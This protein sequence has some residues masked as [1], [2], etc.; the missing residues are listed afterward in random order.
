[1]DVLWSPSADRIENSPL[2]AYLNWLERRAGRP[3]PDHDALWAW[4]VGDL[5]RFW[6]SVAEY[7]DVAFSTPWTRVRTADPMPRTRW[8]PGGR[9]NWA[10][11]ALRR[12]A[13]DGTALVCVREG[14]EPAREVTFGQLRRSVA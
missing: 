2:R 9:L 10:Q 12:G 14:G 1:M 11:H 4:S 6:T 5:D 3:F 13:D 8:F 7:Y